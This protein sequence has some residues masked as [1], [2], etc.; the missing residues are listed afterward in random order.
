MDSILTIKKI[1]GSAGLSDVDQSSLL[2]AISHLDRLELK[3][4]TELLNNDNSVINFI[5][6]IHKK[7]QI[8]FVSHDKNLLQKIFQQELEK[9]LEINK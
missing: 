2:S 7:K 6:E 8:A 4:L 3:E 5:V 9:L 1:L